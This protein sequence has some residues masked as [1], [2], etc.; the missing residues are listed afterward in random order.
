MRIPES[1]SP[2]VVAWLGYCGLLPFVTLALPGAWDANH[3]E[4]W[5]KM[6]P[7]YGALILR[8]VGT[9]HWA[10]AMVHP[11]TRGQA[12][13]GV[14]IWIVMPSLC[15]GTVFFFGSLSGGQGITV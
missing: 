5:R 1:R 13:S 7:C 2:A 6:L 4:R 8:F 9:L 3:R 12:A 10:Y 15:L 14:Y 11:A